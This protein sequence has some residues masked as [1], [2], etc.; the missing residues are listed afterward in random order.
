MR[1]WGSGGTVN[2]SSGGMDI[3]ASV[4]SGGTLNVSAGGVVSALTLNDPN[5]PGVTA[6]C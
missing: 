4:G 3:H 2:V 1:L 5:D 6:G